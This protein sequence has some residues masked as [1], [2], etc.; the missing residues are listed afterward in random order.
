M[1]APTSAP[2]KLGLEREIVDQAVLERAISRFR[3]EGIVLPTLIS[4]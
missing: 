4:L 1:S 3:D 2:S